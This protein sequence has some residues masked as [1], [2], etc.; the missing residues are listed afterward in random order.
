M[1]ILSMKL[2]KVDFVESSGAE[3]PPLCALPEPGVNL[4]THRAPIIQPSA[5]Y[6]FANAERD[7]VA[8]WLFF[9]TSTP[10]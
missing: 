8:S 3:E 9:S 10:L 1:I 6:L 4:S 5:L 2:K 7:R